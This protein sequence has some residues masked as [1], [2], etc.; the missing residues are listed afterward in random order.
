MSKEATSISG[1]AWLVG[2]LNPSFLVL[3]FKQAHYNVLLPEP[4]HPGEPEPFLTTPGEVLQQFF[5]PSGDP[6]DLIGL[7][8]LGKEPG[9]CRLKVRRAC[10]R[11]SFIIVS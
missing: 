10:V 4:R 7:Y 5:Q 1:V 2:Q 9:D 8:D 11:M 3:H 6:E